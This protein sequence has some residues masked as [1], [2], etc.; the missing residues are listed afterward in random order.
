MLSLPTS[1]RTTSMLPQ[2]HLYCLDHLKPAEHPTKRTWAGSDTEISIVGS[3]RL[4]LPTPP[5]PTSLTP[6][7][8]LAA[9]V[10]VLSG[11]PDIDVLFFLSFSTIESPNR[12][13]HSYTWLGSRW[14]RRQRWT[15]QSSC[16]RS[17]GAAEKR[18]RCWGWICRRR[19]GNCRGHV[20]GRVL[21]RW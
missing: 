21:G 13:L 16:S 2:F 18:S 17:R 5:L 9:M 6:T 20:V 8:R 15:R 4:A 10:I 7:H 11:L 3:E 14:P 12:L 19:R 1:S